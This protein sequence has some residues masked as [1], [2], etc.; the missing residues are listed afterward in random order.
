MRYE[1]LSDCLR[2]LKSTADL[3][4]GYP[5]RFPVPS[6]KLNWD[7][8]FP[9][10]NPPYYTSERILK[11]TEEGRADPEDPRQ[12]NFHDPKKYYSLHQL[13]F[14]EDKDRISID[15]AQP[16][17]CS[18]FKLD[19]DGYPL[20]P[21]GRTGIRG[22]GACKHWGPI[23]ASDA[24]LT[25]LNPQAHLLEVLTIE[26]A[27]NGEIAFPGGKLDPEEFHKH[28]AL[29]ELQEEAV[30]LKAPL[31]FFNEEIVFE[32]VMADPRNTDNAWYESRVFHKHITPEQEKQLLLRPSSDA[33][34]VDWRSIT[35]DL[36]SHMFAGHG[37]I[38][39]FILHQMLEEE[40]KIWAIAEQRRSYIRAQIVSTIG[41]PKNDR[42]QQKH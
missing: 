14:Q 13:K 41:L 12:L 18:G 11:M 21:L 25:R 7:E 4:P 24:V 10:Y 9:E 37:Q 23:Q 15:P 39:K 8:P 34:R 1:P 40:K 42:D 19:N 22:R 3:F 5:K 20:N 32:G 35:P 2:D 16:K 26:R 28:A 38:L 27:D 29:R 6:S 36:L 17:N 33:K 31:Y 30:V